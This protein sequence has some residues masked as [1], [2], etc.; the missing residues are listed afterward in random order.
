M[1][2]G[3][4]FH[5]GRHGWVEQERTPMPQ[6][7]KPKLIDPHGRAQAE[8]FASLHHRQRRERGPKPLR[9]GE[10][11]TIV[12]IAITVWLFFFA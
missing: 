4:I 10:V 9:S 6:E 12:S 2:D 11:A 8:A 1:S 3:R 7:R 5:L